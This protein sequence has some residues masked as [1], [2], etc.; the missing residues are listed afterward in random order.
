MVRYSMALPVIRVADKAM[1]RHA[2][3]FMVVALLGVALLAA[4]PGGSRANDADAA[5]AF[6]TS[7]TNQAIEKLTDA[8]LPVLEREQ[9]FRSLFRANFELDERHHYRLPLW[10]TTGSQ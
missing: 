2:L 9:S 3:R 5:A 1:L 7:L 8:S 6:L 10:V 4:S